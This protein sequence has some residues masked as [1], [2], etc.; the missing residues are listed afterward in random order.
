MDKI[1]NWFYKPVFTLVC[2]AIA[3]VLFCYFVYIFNMF[4][5]VVAA[6]VESG[7][8]S[9][10]SNF[11]DMSIYIMSNSFSYLFYACSFFFF[12]KVISIIKPKAVKEKVIEEVTEMTDEAVKEDIETNKDETVEEIIEA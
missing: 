4:Y 7:A 3:V 11:G 10:S 8:Y 6:S 12:G 5:Q 1:K 9:W 2:Y